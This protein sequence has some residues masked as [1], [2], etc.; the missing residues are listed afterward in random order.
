MRKRD[1]SQLKGG[2]KHMYLRLHRA[3][4]IGYLN[5]HGIGPTLTQY[6]ICSVTLDNLLTQGDKGNDP[7]YRYTGT[8]PSRPNPVL[9]TALDAL[10]IADKSKV[11]AEMAQGSVADLR[12]ELRELREQFA[13]FQ[14]AV[15]TDLATRFL[16]PLLEFMKVPDTLD[17]KTKADPL[18]V[19]ALL[20]GLKEGGIKCLTNGQQ[21]R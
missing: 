14:Q 19:T 4:I 7:R 6:H 20:E 1:P 10:N 17:V 16:K 9:L 11:I 18:S 8:A 12:R 15:A 3:E 2:A 21:Q 5:A 13:L